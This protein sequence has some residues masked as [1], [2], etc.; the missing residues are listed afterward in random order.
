MANRA[1]RQAV[2]AKLI[3][4][5]TDHSC[6]RNSFREIVLTRALLQCNES[7]IVM[8]SLSLLFPSSHSLVFYDRQKRLLVNPERQL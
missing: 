6:Q 1:G 5:A 2:V 7:F 8:V 4:N 3:I